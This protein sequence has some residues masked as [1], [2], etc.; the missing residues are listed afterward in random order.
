MMSYSFDLEVI[1]IYVEMNSLFI[2]IIYIFDTFTA[3]IKTIDLIIQFVQSLSYS[4][5]ENTPRTNFIINYYRT[6]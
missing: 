2:R 6:G 4:N 3:V 1:I 5:N